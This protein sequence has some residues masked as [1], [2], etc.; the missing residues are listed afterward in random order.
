MKILFC[1]ECD[2]PTAIAVGSPS[3]FHVVK[4]VKHKQAKA[5]EVPDSPMTSKEQQ[6]PEKYLERLSKEHGSKASK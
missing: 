1:V 6:H 3:G 5:I 4:G 2:P